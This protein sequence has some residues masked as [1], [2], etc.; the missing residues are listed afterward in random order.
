MQWSNSLCLCFTQLFLSQVDSR[1]FCSRL[2]TNNNSVGCHGDLKKKKQQLTVNQHNTLELSCPPFFSLPHFSH[3]IT[4]QKL[5]KMTDFRRKKTASP[6][7][8]YHLLSPSTTSW[9]SNLSLLSV[10]SLLCPIQSL[11]QLW[12]SH[13]F[14]SR[15]HN[16]HN[17]LTDLLALQWE[18]KPQRERVRASVRERQREP[19]THPKTLHQ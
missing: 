7:S 2:L 3:L 16:N 15:H 9:F 12:S 11:F 13:L 6:L 5:L 17:V 19:P 10:P 4:Y 1:M 8:T 14:I 18:V